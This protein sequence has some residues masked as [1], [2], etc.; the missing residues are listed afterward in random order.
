MEKNYN[1]LVNLLKT[2]TFINRHSDIITKLENSW[3]E[4]DLLTFRM[5]IS[6]ILRLVKVD[7]NNKAE[8][9]ITL[10]NELLQEINYGAATTRFRSKRVNLN[11]L[12]QEE[13]NKKLAEMARIKA[14]KKEEQRAK[15]L[16]KEVEQLN[17]SEKNIKTNQT[18]LLKLKIKKKQ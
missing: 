13:E 15:Q 1:N 2:S 18:Q 5:I 9:I 12:S 8:N 14:A 6:N 11:K 7:K 16:D 4:K 10:C 17:K 3:N